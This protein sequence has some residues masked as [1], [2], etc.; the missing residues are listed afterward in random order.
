MWDLQYFKGSI[1]YIVILWNW[2]FTS[3]TK[4]EMSYGNMS[5]YNVV[6]NFKLMFVV[7]SLWTNVEKKKKKDI[8]S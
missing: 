5:S 6:C 7:N 1:H 3:C 4:D 2:N 8:F